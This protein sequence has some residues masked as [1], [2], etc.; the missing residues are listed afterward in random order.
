MDFHIDFS[1]YLMREIVKSG[2]T[3]LRFFEK[4]SKLLVSR[5]L[6]NKKIYCNL[7]EFFFRFPYAI[8]AALIVCDFG[9]V[10]SKKTR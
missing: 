9:E 3:F 7:V 1:G 8:E 4:I 2:R 10:D 5:Q 6:Q